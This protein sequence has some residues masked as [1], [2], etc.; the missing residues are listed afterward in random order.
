MN[1]KSE[2]SRKWRFYYD[3]GYNNSLL[4]ILCHVVYAT[5]GFILQYLHLFD[6]PQLPQPDKGLH[7]PVGFGSNLIFSTF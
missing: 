4:T 7:S 1:A 3:I 5:L 6:K 2:V